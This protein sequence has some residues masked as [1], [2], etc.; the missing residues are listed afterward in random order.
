MR[1]GS[2]V[3][4]RHVPFFLAL[5]VAADAWA[6][7]L[8]AY[9]GDVLL[10]GDV[11]VV[12]VVSNFRHELFVGEVDVDVTCKRIGISSITFLMELI[13]SDR[14]AGTVNFVVAK[15]DPQRI[16]AVPLTAAQRAALESIPAAAG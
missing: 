7:A 16:H 15:V 4:D 1:D 8:Q 11:A 9:C 12:S 6:L 14:S 10:P 2:T 13:Q 3:N 5:E